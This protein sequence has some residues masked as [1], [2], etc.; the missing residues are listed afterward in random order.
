MIRYVIFIFVAAAIAAGGPAFAVEVE[1]D[2]DARWVTGGVG[3][4]ERLDMLALL[5]DYNLRILT[6]AERSGAFL[7]NVQ[8]VVRDAHD[9]VVLETVLDGPFLLARLRPGEYEVLA[10]YRG[11]PHART[12]TIPSTG[13]REL[14]LYWAVVDVESP[15]KGAPR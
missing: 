13:R 2:G 9:R 3:E 12:V 1:G 10:T 7:A 14:F 4:A 15:P 6:A 11:R 5:P 8:V